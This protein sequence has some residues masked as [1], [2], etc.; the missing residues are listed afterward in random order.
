MLLDFLPDMLTL[1]LTPSPTSLERR[2]KVMQEPPRATANTIALA[3][4]GAL[5]LVLV[6]CSAN[7][8]TR[9]P[10]PR[11]G[12]GSGP[13]GRIEERDIQL[14]KAATRFYGDLAAGEAKKQQ[15]LWFVFRHDWTV[16]R[17]AIG[18]NDAV[19]VEDSDVTYAGSDHGK[20]W[21]SVNAS[22]GKKFPDLQGIGTRETQAN[23][24]S[25][26]GGRVAIAGDTVMVFWARYAN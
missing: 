22:L 7:P 3:S 15:L 18:A 8:P 11:L 1:G 21:W 10:L 16:E 20:K 12:I 26:G 9:A 13:D 24:E 5:G 2:I 25:F 17:H 19:T 23:V 4:W 6:A 14:Q